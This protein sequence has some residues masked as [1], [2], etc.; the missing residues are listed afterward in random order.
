MNRPTKG[1]PLNK[2]GRDI[3]ETAASL[4]E[5]WVA[6]PDILHRLEARRQHV[7]QVCQSEGLDVPSVKYQP[8]AWEFLINH[9]YALVWCNVFKAASSTWMWNF[10]LLAGY[11]Q[12]QL[13]KANEA[14]VAMA[15]HKYPR[16]SVKKLQ[17]VLNTSPPPLSFMI[18]RHPLLRLVSAYRNKILAGN[19]IYKKISKKIIR[20]YNALGPPVPQ[21]TKDG[22]APRHKVALVPS[23]P[24]FVQWV[25][26]EEARGSNL[27]MH[28]IPQA[29]FCTPCLVDFYVFAKMETLDEDANYIIFTSG[30]NKVIKPKVINRSVGVSTEEAAR[31]L[32]CQLSASQM[33]GLLHLYRLDF[34]LFEYEAESYRTCVGLKPT[35]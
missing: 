5:S 11:T 14:P 10:N 22:R 15:R 18:T 28:W 34:Q 26:D 6:M 29:R 13:L 16:P 12:E 24:Q 1:K 27:D 23:F 33:D 7:K 17:K 35:H 25:L 30:I 3:I 20:T 21:E 32:L 31:K 4:P 9:N 8:N 2:P 19:R